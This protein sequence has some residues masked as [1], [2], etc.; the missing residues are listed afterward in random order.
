MRYLFG[1]DENHAFCQGRETGR[2]L[3]SA[4]KMY[5][6]TKP[7]PDLTLLAS[8]AKVDLRDSSALEWH[9]MKHLAA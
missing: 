8:R 5:Y 9:I 1:I 7:A 3:P 6:V 4:E 2:K